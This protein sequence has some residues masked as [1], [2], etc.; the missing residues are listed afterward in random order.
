MIA[1]E[2][3][4]QF[5]AAIQDKDWSRV[6]NLGEAYLA[7]NGP[8]SEVVYNLGLAY[9][10]IGNS[11]MAV[12]LF[13]SLPRQGANASVY[14]QALNAALAKVGRN[15]ADLDL[16]AHGLTAIASQTFG[17]ARSADFHASTAVLLPIL[18]SL[19]AARWFF[20][21]NS[22]NSHRFNKM[23]LLNYGIFS[24]GVLS[25]VSVLLLALS[26]VYRPTWCAVISEDLAVVRDK[27]DVS[28]TGLTTLAGGTPVLVLGD[29]GKAWIW[30]LESSGVQGWMDALQVRCVN[31][32]K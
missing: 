14:E 2:F 5:N 28:G 32:K 29:T 17:V 1:D 13:L 10:E 26:L 15:S 20:R 19:I 27:P 11:Q 24:F 18:I 21:K 16:G 31:D 8:A 22:A 9:L 30:V 23:A 25:F 7:Q 3:K 6:I 12:S 4:N